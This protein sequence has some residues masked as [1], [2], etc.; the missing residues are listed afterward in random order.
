[1]KKRITFKI[2]ALVLIQ[3]F[4]LLDICPAGQ[5]D[6]AVS[7]SAL[8]PAVSMDTVNLQSVFEQSSGLEGDVEFLEFETADP[9]NNDTNNPGLNQTTK[10]FT[11]NVGGIGNSG[12][13][14]NIFPP[15]PPKPVINYSG[16]QLWLRSVLPYPYTK[17]KLEEEL[18][19]MGFEISDAEISRK[20]LVELITVLTKDNLI[21][22]LNEKGIARVEYLPGIVKDGAVLNTAV[23]IPKPGVIVFTNMFFSQDISVKVNLIKDAVEHVAFVEEKTITVDGSSEGQ[24]VFADYEQNGDMVSLAQLGFPP[25][26]EAMML[27]VREISKNYYDSNLWAGFKRFGFY[28]PNTISEI[29]HIEHNKA[30]DKPYE[31]IL[32]ISKLVVPSFIKLYQEYPELFDEL[33]KALLAHEGGNKGHLM[34]WPLTSIDEAVKYF[35]WANLNA[36]AA[37]VLIQ[38]FINGVYP[39]MLSNKFRDKGTPAFHKWL[40]SLVII[41]ETLTRFN[42]DRNKSEPFGV[43]WK[44]FAANYGM[45]VD[46]GPRSPAV[47]LWFHKHF[48]KLEINLE[49]AYSVQFSW[50]DKDERAATTVEISQIE[51]DYQKKIAQNKVAH[52]RP[53]VSNSNLLGRF[54]SIF[55][56]VILTAMILPLVGCADNGMRIEPSLSG[57]FL[58]GAVITS[59]VFWGIKRALFAFASVEKKTTVLAYQAIKKNNAEKLMKFYENSPIKDKITIINTTA[60]ILKSRAAYANPELF[61]G[62]LIAAL[63]EN[64]KAVVNSIRV[65][66][67]EVF[68]KETDRLGRINKDLKSV[69]RGV[70]DAYNRAN[71]NAKV[72]AEKI[73]ESLAH[74]I[75]LLAR[76]GDLHRKD[77]FVQ[78]VMRDSTLKGFFD[79][80]RAEFIY[81]E[82]LRG[83]TS[84]M[85]LSVSAMALVDARTSLFE[86]ALMEIGQEGADVN[87]VK[88]AAK[89]LGKVRT[90]SL[91]SLAES[92]DKEG[93]VETVREI[94]PSLE[95]AGIDEEKLELF[96]SNI[97]SILI[98]GLIMRLAY[99]PAIEAAAMEIDRLGL[100]LDKKKAASML[101]STIIGGKISQ[102]ELLY[103]RF[104][105]QLDEVLYELHRPAVEALKV[106]ALRPS[107]TQGFILGL[108]TIAQEE[109]KNMDEL[110]LE[111]LVAVIKHLTLVSP[112]GAANIKPVEPQK[113]V[114]SVGGVQTK[115]RVTGNA[116]DRVIET[117]EIKAKTGSA[118]LLALVEAAI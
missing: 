97:G 108:K 16:M 98:N 5:I 104:K 93:F 17:K 54:K 69:V 18:N 112:Q 55:G 92:A 24:L 75:A 11:N 51:M 78:Q 115:G 44:E 1:M 103:K 26:A 9:G 82:I 47:I 110:I 87:Y 60:E 25:E 91:L 109:G 41:K 15:P 105:P 58:I 28:Q 71:P 19:Q 30:E 32:A 35:D 34:R 33:I 95:K 83:F 81:K 86:D 48:R 94:A 4:L 12:A 6:T 118:S 68:M 96:A 27:R 46:Q 117:G 56:S 116:A 70:L 36:L 66:A 43:I 38:N 57:K 77:V 37:Q 42:F 113:T 13:E 49:A 31:D 89:E 7:K 21:E 61:E 102:S 8:A 22:S 111:Q 39:E 14:G 73:S 40:H 74:I 107:G 100:G 65:K 99:S 50:L 2:I 3:A 88:K 84:Y 62:I 106:F 72:Q 67:L 80:E 29:M 79:N 23:T 114:S 53:A 59:L 76:N 64:N 20:Q 10:I 52:G 90:V 63:R 85:A 101:A 45:V